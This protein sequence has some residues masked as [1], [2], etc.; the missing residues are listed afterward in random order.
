MPDWNIFVFIAAAGLFVVLWGRILWYFDE[1]SN[2]LP[3]FIF[4]LMTFT[5][6]TFPEIKSLLLS[7]IYYIFGLVGILAFS[8]LYRIDMAGLFGFKIHFIPLIVL[9]IM[10]QI[11]LA[12]F[13]ISIYLQGIKHK[14]INPFLEIQNSPWIS[15]IM[16]LPKFFIPFAPV[17]GGLL[18]EFFFRGI[19]LIILVTRLAVPPFLAIL[20]VTFLFLVEQWLQLRTAVQR[21]MIG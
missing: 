3:R 1:K 10:A 6:M 14:R 2:L 18:E 20:F 21:I 13:F 15:G 4:Y 11:S 8:F 7:L 19:L 9:G 16:K 17:I 12:N 5:R